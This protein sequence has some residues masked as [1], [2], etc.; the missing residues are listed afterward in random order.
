MFSKKEIIMWSVDDDFFTVNGERFQ[1][2]DVIEMEEDD[3]NLDKLGVMNVLV[4]LKT[5]R[6]LNISY[7][8]Y[9]P[10]TTKSAPGAD[11]AINAIEFIK[12]KMVIM[13]I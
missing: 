11:E 13:V 2:D 3:S 1:F 5:G 10:G 7:G 4:K 12:S 6:K 8:K 9:Y